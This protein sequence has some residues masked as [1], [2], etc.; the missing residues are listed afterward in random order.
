MV[1]E[2]RRQG[3]GG[4]GLNRL[5]EQ[6]ANICG[7]QRIE[8]KWLL[9]PSMRVGHQWLGAVA[10]AGQPALN[11]RVKTLKSMALDLAGPAMAQAAA[12]L[13]SDRAGGILLDRVFR[14]LV[15]GRLRYLGQLRPSTGLAETLHR[16]I[17]AVRLAGL[18]AEQLDPG[19][20]EVAA[21]GGE[22]RL[23]LREYLDELHAHR[24]VDYAG[25]LRMAVDRLIGDPDTLPSDVLLLVPEDLRL[26]VLEEELLK[27]VPAGRL[28]RLAVDAPQE[29]PA[30]TVDMFHA[31][32]E[33]NEVRE[34][35]RRALAEG[36][37]WDEIELL[38][39][40]ADFYGPL[41]YETLAA[42]LA[43]ERAADEELPLTLAEGIACRY[44]RPGRLLAAWVA[45]AREG[46]AQDRLVK[47]VREGLLVL[48]GAGEASSMPR[49]AAVLRGVAIG[50]GRERYL[51]Q[52]DRAIAA[53]E[54]VVPPGEEDDATEPARA[55]ARLEPLRTVRPLVAALVELSPDAEADARTVLVAARRLLGELARTL[56][57]TDNYAREALVQEIDDLLRWASGDEPLGLDAWEWLA[58]LPSETRILGSGP[59]PGCLH[60]ASITTGG[61]SGRP[62][63]FLVGLDDGRFPGSGGQDPLLLDAERR[64]IDS[65]LPTAAAQL[66][67]R[68]LGFRRLLARLRGRVTLSF[69]GHD[70]VDDR[71]QFPSPLLVDVYRALSG[72]VD[73]TQHDLLAALPEPAAFA[74]RAP[75]HAV[76][77]TEWWLWRLCGGGPQPGD[78]ELLRAA[79]PHLA[80]G[81]AAERQRASDA[82]TDYDGRVPEAAAALDPTAERGPVMSS[83]RLEC[84]G[85]CALAYFFQCGLGL[86]RPEEFALDASRWLEPPVAGALL[87]AVF[88]QFFRTRLERNEAPRLAEH[89]SELQATLNTAIEEHRRVYPP[90]NESAFQT[91][92]RQLRQSAWILLAEEE[93]YCRQTGARPVYLE[94]CLGLAPGT[95]TPLDCREPVPVD[96]GGG[97]TLRSCGKVDRIDHLGGKDYAIWDYKTGSAWR[98]RPGD[99][100]HEGRVVQPA[101]YL[102]MV[103]RRLKEVVPGAR[104]RQFGF[105][106]PSDRE[107]GQRIQWSA[108]QLADGRRLLA[109]LVGTIRRGAFLATT[110]AN[111]CKFCPYLTICGDVQAVA[112]ASQCKLAVGDPL[113]VELAERR[114]HDAG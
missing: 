69:P 71:P 79:F 67:E 30:A 24:L 16:S 42:L 33:V 65:R 14:R 86:R 13:A 44:S 35:L 4:L 110:D 38:F 114:G 58:A 50:A 108:E 40:D 29:Q 11:V 46:C 90:P 91:Q 104:V 84:L 61:H 2:P 95:G 57:M 113:L 20:F 101:L 76:S 59:R 106:F 78:D 55:S 47:M 82:F 107:R 7:A 37:P 87:H 1:T 105:F 75:E 72:N 54:R 56:T 74:P 81:Q 60:A 52:L 97:L 89:W 112:R 36:T 77:A 15:S 28:V 62:R 45:W 70:L 41:I 27:R 18:E 64:A 48:P 83:S 68:I 8:E 19:R 49:L 100:F 88:E 63:T 94:A 23:I 32:G 92:C 25:V 3:A 98:Y 93:E 21:K 102:S 6:L 103:A 51:V 111:D 5:T 10:R 12:E 85:A 34:V 99:P 66:D 26:T 109:S 73:A 80:Q 43:D 53:A 22:I 39:S 96:L 31:L 17:Q 9:A